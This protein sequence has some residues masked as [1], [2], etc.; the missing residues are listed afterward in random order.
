MLRTSDLLKGTTPALILA[1][2]AKEDLYGYRI[3]KLIQEESDDALKLGE[4]SVYPVLH[5]LESKG[6]VKGRWETREIGPARKYYA[7]TS[8]GKKELK[9]AAA[10]WRGYSTAVEG[11]LG[12]AGV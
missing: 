2:L 9:T 11:V 8:K 3:I 10:T 12:F 7:L 6:L 1:A 4:G 5:A